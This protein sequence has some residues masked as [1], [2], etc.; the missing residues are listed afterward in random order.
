MKSFHEKGKKAL[1]Y[2][3]GSQ[4]TELMATVARTKLNKMILRNISR[5]FRLRI[6]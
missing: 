5:S 3:V 2:P 1:N 4:C 6:C